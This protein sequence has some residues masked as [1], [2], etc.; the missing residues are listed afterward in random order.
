MNSNGAEFTFPHAFAG[1]PIAVTDLNA[2]DSSQYY[3]FIRGLSAT[4][5]TVKLNAGVSGN[6]TGYYI[7]IGQ[8]A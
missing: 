1:T 3:S 4:T 7:A 2:S 8:S 6:R 5:I